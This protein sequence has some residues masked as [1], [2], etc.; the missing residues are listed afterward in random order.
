MEQDPWKLGASEKGFEISGT[1]QYSAIDTNPAISTATFEL[2]NAVFLI[3]GVPPTF[4][5]GIEIG[6]HELA[7]RDDVTIRFTELEFRGVRQPF[8]SNAA[9]PMSTMTF[10]SM[11]ESPPFFPSATTSTVSGAIRGGSS[12]RSI[13]DLGATVKVRRIPEPSSFVLIAIGLLAL[14]VVSRNS[15]RARARCLLVQR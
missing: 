6:F 1:V 10:T 5:G 12:Y 2:T 9:L 11:F 14:L 13:V 4:F 3:E 8:I 15:C 7:S